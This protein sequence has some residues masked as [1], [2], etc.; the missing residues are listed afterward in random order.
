M[1]QVDMEME[2]GGQSAPAPESPV[3]KS[4]SHRI[5]FPSA[6]EMRQLFQEAEVDSLPR[7]WQVAGLTSSAEKSLH[8]LAKWVRTPSKFSSVKVAEFKGPSGTGKTFAVKALA[9]E[10]GDVAHYWELD[11][12]KILSSYMNEGQQNMK[13]FFK[14]IAKDRLE[15]YS[16][17]DKENLIVGIHEGETIGGKRGEDRN[18][19][20]VVNALITS[21][22]ELEKEEGRQGRILVV[23]TTN[24]ELDDTL[25]R[26]AAAN[27][28]EFKLP[29][30]EGRLTTLISSVNMQMKAQE[31]KGHA[32][33]FN[34]ELESVVH[35]LR[36]ADEG[37]KLGV[38]KDLAKSTEW[39]SFVKST[40][41]ASQAD[42]SAAVRTA[43][44]DAEESG[45]RVGIEDVQAV[46]QGMMP[47]IRARN[48]SD[49]TF[50][51]V[52]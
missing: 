43:L 11:A 36:D 44:E 42:I 23:F 52:N 20:N 32:S 8:R 19:S 40:A 27:V 48:A 45:K 18:F 38:L 1:A 33:Y 6:R 35:G 9:G 24:K 39:R 50:R 37:G 29:T 30:D 14:T 10:V 4:T 28:V 51:R 3:R 21:L 2:I 46:M 15:A 16:N 12:G 5:D 26:R 25:E 41:G 17:G 34:D 13:D 47:A 31:E 49:E 22:D 7:F